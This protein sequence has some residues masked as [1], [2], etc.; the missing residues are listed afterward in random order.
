M[1]HIKS[2]EQVS[3]A[4][5]AAD[6]ALYNLKNCQIHLKSGNHGL[7]SF[8]RHRHLNQAKE[9][10]Y[11]ADQALNQLSTKLN[12]IDLDLEDEGLIIFGNYRFDGLMADILAQSQTSQI[13]RQ[14]IEAIHQVKKARDQLIALSYDN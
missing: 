4:I 3:D 13:R 1:C 6:V 5:A 11:Q 2:K 12:H 14:L 9:D 10:L 8:G 7:L